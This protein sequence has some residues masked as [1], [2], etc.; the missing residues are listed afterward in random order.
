L[1]Y[2][3]NIAYYILTMVKKSKFK[4]PRYKTNARLI[5]GKY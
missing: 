2:G 1:T 3:Y 5:R 4:K